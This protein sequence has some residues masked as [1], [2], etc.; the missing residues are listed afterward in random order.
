MTQHPRLTGTYFAAED[1]VLYVGPLVATDLHAHHAAQIVLAPSGV[2]VADAEGSSVT[3][4][5]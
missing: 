4:F 5:A 3:S 1:Y 2:A